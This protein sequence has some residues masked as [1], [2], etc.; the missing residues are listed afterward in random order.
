MS[1][2]SMLWA[3]STSGDGTAAY[4]E[5]ES[6]RLFKHLVGG[7]PATE[8]VLFEVENGLV[9]TGGTSPLS[10][11]TGSAFVNGYFYWNTAPVNQVVP[12][13]IVGTTGHRVV[14]RV[15]YSAKTVRI[16]L[17]SSTD[18]ISAYPA[19]TQTDGVTWEIPLANLSI[20]TGGIITLVDARGFVHMPTKVS[21]T[22]YDDL[23]I[24]TTK[25]VNGA[26]EDTKLRDSGPLSVIGRSVNSTGD[27]ADI[28]ANVDGYVLRR[29]G[30]TLGFGQIATAGVAD[31]AIT[32][33]KLAAA[34]S[35]K[36]VTNGDSH[37]HVGGDGAAI[38]TNAISNLAVTTGKINDLAVTTAK[39]NDLAVT[40]DKLAAL[41]VSTGKIAAD[42]VDD[43]KVGNRVP[44]FYRRQGGS[45][46]DWS[47]DGIT[48]RTP[49]TVR[50]QSGVRG[51]T[52]T[53]GN[54]EGTA[55]ITFPAAFSDVPIVYATVSAPSSGL[56]FLATVNTVTATTA[57]FSVYLAED[58]TTYG[59]D[60]S[61]NWLAIGPE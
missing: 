19:L 40:E 1:E 18:G 57:Q 13:P 7:S 28:S 31:G 24:G 6:T 44:Q 20:T 25:L 55:G 56:H 3:T 2:K 39:I 53:L 52:M 61:I 5:T 45:A 26:V 14:L 42:A 30:T 4:T 27:P 35:G 59:G 41:A 21:G 8:G 11:D 58:G 17:I 16:A 50:M 46:T 23:S 36:L 51:C 43:T 49:T 15:N 38:G 12:T 60:V 37:D 33:V 10:V 34:V 9:V 54:R 29:S 32:E 22:M 47:V 48:N